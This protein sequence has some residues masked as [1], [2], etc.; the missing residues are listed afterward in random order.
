M[1]L[2]R[3]KKYSGWVFNLLKLEHS[4]KINKLFTGREMQVEI[5]LAGQLYKE[6]LFWIRTGVAWWTDTGDF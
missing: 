6:I 1:L 2:S 5:A 4:G 3:Y